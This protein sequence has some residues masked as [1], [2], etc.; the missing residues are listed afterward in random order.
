[1]LSKDFGCGSKA[2]DNNLLLGHSQLIRMHL[3]VE[4]QVSIYC[5]SLD[6]FTF[7]LDERHLLDVA[8]LKVKASNLNVLHV[9]LLLVQLICTCFQR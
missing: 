7:L 2:G 1:M 4:A 5:H 9:Y 6:I 8:K 3:V